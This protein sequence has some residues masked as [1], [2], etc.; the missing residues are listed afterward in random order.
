MA[1]QPYPYQGEC[2][3][4]LNGVRKKGTPRA[5]VVMASGLGKT[6]TAAFDVKRYLQE[7]GGR[8]LYLCNNNDI[9]YQAKTTFQ[10]ILDG[11]FTYGFFHG[12]DKEERKVDCLF[13]SFQTMESWAKHFGK[14][15]FDYIVVDES[16]HSHADTYRTT[17]QYF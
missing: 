4:V 12:N 17:V 3:E 16:H 5:L 2:L 7:A 9:L 14:N 11:P 15:E 13:A 8:M 1:F 10:A 6:V